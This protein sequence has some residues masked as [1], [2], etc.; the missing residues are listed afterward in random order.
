LVIPSIEG[1]Q[2][3]QVIDMLGHIVMNENVTGSYDKQLNLT[4]GVYVVR[5]DERTQKMV[6]K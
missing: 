1:V 4:P 5:L 3:L 6:V 2:T